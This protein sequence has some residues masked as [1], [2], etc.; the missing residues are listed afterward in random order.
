MLMRVKSKPHAVVIGS[1]F[2]GLAAAIRLGAR[3]YRVTVLEKLDQPGGRACVFR[4]DGFTFDAGPTIITA[5]FLLEDL[6][7]LCGRTFSDDIDLRALDCFYRIL[8]DDGRHYDCVADGDAMKREIARISPDD[9]DGYERFMRRSEE[10]FRIG[11]EKLSHMPFGKDCGRYGAAAHRPQRLRHRREIREA[12]L[13]AFCAEL[14]S[15]V[16]RRQPIPD[17]VDLLPD[18]ISRTPLGSAF[19]D[20]RNRRGGARSCGAD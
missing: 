18:F 2:G 1:G 5:P 6:W 17:D 16:R 4:Q 19:P 13:S 8:F 3:G 7:K 12:S 11:F 14:S 15:A 20:G 9:V 10:I